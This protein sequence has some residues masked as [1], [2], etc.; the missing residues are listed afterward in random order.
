VACN[1]TSGRDGVLCR[2]EPIA[3][4]KN[5]AYGLAPYLSSRDMERV[6]RVCAASKRSGRSQLR[7]HF[8]RRRPVGGVRESGFD[9]EGEREATDDYLDTSYLAL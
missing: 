3:A 9:H 1:G 2:I 8:F 5:T 4:A 6:M 7:H